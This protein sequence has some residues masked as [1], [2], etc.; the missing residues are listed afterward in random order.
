MTEDRPAMAP[1]DLQE[2]RSSPW[3]RAFGVALRLLVVGLVGAGLGAGAY[4]GVPA[5]YRD[6]IEPVQQ[7]TQRLDQTQAD[8]ANQQVSQRSANATQLAQLAEI[9]GEIAQQGEALSALQADVGS[10][11]SSQPTLEAGVRSLNQMNADLAD[12]KA[13]AT[14]VAGQIDAMNTAAAMP[15]PTVQALG[16][17]LDILRLMQ[18]VSQARLSLA[19]GNLVKAGVEVQAA[20]AALA[21]LKSRAGVVSLATLDDVETR[22]NLAQQE[23][24][25][26]PSVAANDL[27]IAWQLLVELSRAQ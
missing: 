7:N 11:K 17:R 23:T 8:L 20:S 25:G 21:D 15:D 16:Q 26:S 18:L 10:L 27:D 3:R 12:L 6:F 14:Q 2:R 1:S 5:A 24:K 4:W 19:A 13:V 22:L 9:Q